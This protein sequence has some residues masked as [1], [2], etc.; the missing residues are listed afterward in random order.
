EGSGCGIWLRDLAEGSGCG[1]RPRDLAI[2][3]A[4]RIGCESLPLW[5]SQSGARG[6][7]PT[8]RFSKRFDVR[9]DVAYQSGDG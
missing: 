7:T 5:I 9:I 3:L 4:V 1:I 2:V 8:D 6:I